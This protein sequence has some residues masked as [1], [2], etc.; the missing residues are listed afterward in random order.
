MTLNGLHLF[1]HQQLIAKNRKV[2][3]KTS[4]DSATFYHSNQ[5]N[6]DFH[7]SVIDFLSDKLDY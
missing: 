7:S 1:T 3:N 4:L 6:G 5:F 2:L